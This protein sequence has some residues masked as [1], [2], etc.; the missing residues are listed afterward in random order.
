MNSL[1]QNQGSVLLYTLLIISLITAISISVS[2]L[3]INELKLS[4][5][6]A[7]AGM[8][9]Y[10]AESGIEKGLYALKI[11]RADPSVNLDDAVTIISGYSDDT[12]I[13][14]ADFDNDQT[15]TE[16]SKIENEEIL[17]NEYEQADYFDVNNA[18]NPDPNMI[19]ES[20]VVQNEGGDNDAWAEV[21]WTAWD[22]TGAIG[23]SNKAKKVIG[24]TDLSGPGWPID[25]SE[26]YAGSGF[27][28]VG[29]RIRIKALFGDLASV[30]ITPFNS[31]GNEVTDLPSH[32]KIKSIGTRS[33]FKQSLT[34]TVPWK[35]PLF[36]LYD[37]VLFSEGE[38][39]KTIILGQPIYSSGTIQVEEAI[40]SVSCGDCPTCM[41]LPVWLAIDCTDTV[42]CFGMGGCLLQN[43]NA[44]FTLP[45]PDTIPA[46]SKYYASLRVLTPASSPLEVLIDDPQAGEIGLVTSFP[47][48]VNYQTC[49]IPESFSL[50]SDP[51]RTIRFTDQSA[52]SIRMDWYQIS[53]YQIFDDCP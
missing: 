36:G 39:Y 23:T 52:N 20:I 3:V 14:D 26:A 38:I 16:T 49:T 51:G 25:L 15:S 17:V 35:V 24:F 53:S 31:T 7:N 21:W 4:S 30:T 32:L 19:V 50:G 40:S 29:Y 1:K 10:A 47:A 22:D 48:D 37:Y 6:A 42:A 27:I 13:N 44:S 5:S 2:V 46:S 45:I 28:P 9:Y 41:A 34:A 33:R 8:A 18:L 12:F 43:N 11:F